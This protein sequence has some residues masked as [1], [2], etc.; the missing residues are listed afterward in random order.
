[1]LTKTQKEFLLADH[2]QNIAILCLA[3]EYSLLQVMQEG[4]M[5]MCRFRSDEEWCHFS[6]NS[7]LPFIMEFFQKNP[8]GQYVVVSDDEVLVS[9]KQQCRFAWS[10]C[11]YRLFQEPVT[12]PPDMAGLVPIH[13]G[14]LRHVYQNSKYQQFLSMDYLSKRLELGGGFCIE[15]D[16]QPVA[17]IMTH[18]D[19]SVGMLHVLEPFRRLGYAKILIEAMSWKVRQTGRVVF[20]HIEPTNEPS[21]KLFGSLGFEVKGKVTWAKTV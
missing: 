2:N 8:G 9:L 15:H 18:D 13:P 7:D 14:H 10:I 6:Y 19:G 1:M 12:N 11:C 17:W 20:A 16:H 3:D 5:L 4:E 21:L